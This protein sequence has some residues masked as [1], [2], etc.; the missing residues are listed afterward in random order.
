M[1]CLAFPRRVAWGVGGLGDVGRGCDGGVGGKHRTPRV[2]S[3]L[4]RG[5]AVGFALR[6]GWGTRAIPMGGRCCGG[7]SVCFELR[8]R[9]D[10]PFVRSGSRIVTHVGGVLGLSG[11]APV[12]ASWGYDWACARWHLPFSQGECLCFHCWGGCWF[13]LIFGPGVGA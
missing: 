7:C 5:V 12:L 2:T 13:S 4:A 6:S 10:F 8:K 1:K 9:G 3:R 11:S